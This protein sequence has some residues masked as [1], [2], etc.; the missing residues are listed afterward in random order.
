MPIKE[1]KYKIFLNFFERLEESRHLT[2]LVYIAALFSVIASFVSPGDPGQEFSSPLFIIF[3][4]ITIP[5]AIL[6]IISAFGIAAY[7]IFMPSISD[8]HI[9]TRVH[10]SHLIHPLTTSLVMGIAGFCI[11]TGSN[12]GWFFWFIFFALYSIQTWVMLRQ[13]MKEGSPEDSR[14]NLHLVGLI[15]GGD[16][17][18]LAAGAKSIPPWKLNTLPE[19]TWIVDVR[20][21]AEFS[22][23]HMQNA[24]NFPWGSGIEAAARSRSKNKPVLVACFSGHRS[25]NVAVMLR[26]LGFTTVYNLNWGILYHILLERGT[27]NSGPFSLTRSHKD[28][29]RRGKDYRGI[30]VGY[31]VSAFLTLIVS[32][33][34]SDRFLV[35]PAIQKTIGAIIFFIGALT[36]YLSKK[37]LGRNFRVFAAPRRSGSLVQDGVYRYVRHP[38]YTAVILTLAGYA[39]IFGTR[40]GFL[41][42]LICSILYVIKAIKEEQLL[43]T[44]YPGYTE[45]SSRTWRFVPYIW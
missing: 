20:T 43:N 12:A 33:I 14:A 2:K 45:Y 6:F 23:N 18:T 4:L 19:D 30:S 7:F 8:G 36:G 22:W 17:L 1:S 41:P 44:H 37:A 40:W 15:F 29:N 25:P 34:D 42:W 3:L 35:D 27:G 32:P 11:Y 9:F 16:L 24:E 38:M 5:A 21:K 26:K 10:G 39:L 31:I 28:P 13:L